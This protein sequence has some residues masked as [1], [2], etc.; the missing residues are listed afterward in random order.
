MSTFITPANFAATIGLAATMMGSIVT[1]KPELGIKMWHF[2]IASSEDFKDPKSENRSLI[3]DELRLFAIR[4]FFIGASLFA[5]AYFGNHKTLAAMCLLGVPV[6]TIDGIVQRRQA[7]K[8]DWWV[9]FA[10]APVFA[11]LGVASWRQQ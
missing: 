10:L 1:L 6:V 2:D 8:A 3:L 9:H 4:E 7:P 11:G 5:A